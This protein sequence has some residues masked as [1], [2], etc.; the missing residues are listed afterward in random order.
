MATLPRAIITTASP[1]TLKPSSAPSSKWI[2]LKFH[3][4]KLTNTSSRVKMARKLLIFDMLKLMEPGSLSSHLTLEP[5]FGVKMARDFWH[6]LEWEKTMSSS[7]KIQM[8][9]T[10]SRV[11]H[12]LKP[13]MERRWSASETQLAKSI[14]LRIQKRHIIATL[15]ALASA[16]NPA[17]PSLTRAMPST[18]SSSLICLV[19][20]ISTR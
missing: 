5:R 15:L 1:T 10:S 13:R 8:F 18:S 7:T 9:K 17:L 11:S 19:W 2:K 20:F 12:Q 4:L 3:I 14:S 16:T 6:I